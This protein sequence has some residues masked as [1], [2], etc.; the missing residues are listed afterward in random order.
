[1]ESAKSPNKRVE[2]LPSVARTAL[3]AARCATA[4][5]PSC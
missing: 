1:M 3:H 5:R 2:S 4:S